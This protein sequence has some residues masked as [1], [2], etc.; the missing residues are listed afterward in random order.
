MA[1][2]G[3]LVGKGR[4]IQCY[5]AEQITSAGEVDEEMI[6]LQRVSF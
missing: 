4:K 1:S 3:K 2:A 6:I 5:Q